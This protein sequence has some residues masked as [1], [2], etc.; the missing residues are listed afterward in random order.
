MPRV[1]PRRDDGWGTLAGRAAPPVPRRR[2]G[3]ARS[4][5]AGPVHHRR[6][7]GPA[8]P[9]AHAALGRGEPEPAF[10]AATDADAL[11]V[12]VR[13]LLLG[14]V[15]PDAAV[16]A[17]LAPLTPGDAAAAGLLVA[18]GAGWRAALDLRPYG[19]ADG[20][21]WWV[22][23]DLGDAGC[24][25]PSP[26]ARPRAQG[27]G[28]VADLGRRHRPARRSAS[29]LDLGTGC[30]VRRCTASRHARR[31]TTTWRREPTRIAAAT[32]LNDVDVELDEGPW[33]PRWRAPLRPDVSNPPS[34]PARAGR[35]RS[36]RLRRRTATRPSP[37]L[38]RD[39]AG[40]SRRRRGQ[41][42]ASWLHVRARTG[43]TGCGPGS[44]PGA[45]RG[46]C[47]ARWPTRRWHVGSAGQ[48]DGWPR[49]GVALRP[50]R[51]RGPGW[52]GWHPRA[53]R[54]SGRPAHAAATDAARPWSSRTSRARLDDPLGPEVEG[55]LDRLDWLRAHADDAGLRPLGS[56]LRRPCCSERWSAPAPRVGRRW[57]PRWPARTGRGGGTR[58]TARPRTC[59][60]AAT[61]RCRSASSWSCSPSRTTGRRTGSWPRRCPR[62]ASSCGTACWCARGRGR[63]AVRAVAA[64]VAEASVRVD[65]GRR[66]HRGPGLLV[67]LGVTARHRGRGARRWPASCT[68]CGSCDGE[69]SAAELGAPLLVVSQFTLYGDT[70]KGRRPSWVAAAPGPVA[71]PL[72]D[73]VVAEL[74]GRGATVETGVFGAYMRSLGERRPVHGP[75]RGV[76]RA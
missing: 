29:A 40:T 53:W 8:R 14:S 54:R 10:R 39:L 49:P 9:G 56:R 24:G 70:R 46:W 59:W 45:T 15:E 1:A 71:S 4:A 41:L 2:E 25:R 23:S 26:A 48:R 22:L 69:R 50:R 6:R 36:P 21:D 57:A 19:V 62:C 32:S 12:L 30:G 17:A 47:S 63:V 34:C 43:P 28:G 5:H 61:G 76:S 35:V 16:V 75:A 60:R 33:R 38:S 68:S 3:P 7:A 67:L 44:R 42:L 11:G 73:A 72:V 13:L 20:P 64:R 55:W 51:R 65:G 58:W 31:S 18:D 37:R 74:R 52:S 66:R 27:R